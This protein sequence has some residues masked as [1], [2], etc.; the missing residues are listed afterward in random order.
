DRR[1]REALRL[2][3]EEGA[4]YDEAEARLLEL[5][6]DLA[7]RV[8]AR[9]QVE[10]ELPLR[11]AGHAS[12]ERRTVVRVVDRAKDRRRRDG[13]LRHERVEVADPD[14]RAVAE[15]PT[16]RIDHR[17]LGV[18]PR[19]R[20]AAREQVLPEA[21]VAAGEVEHFVSLPQ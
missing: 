13:R 18:D 2:R 11:E 1:P 3:D 21:A 17:R 12:E 14:R 19:V 8:L 20:E 10:D 4:Q 5:G 9:V 7:S 15:P 6:N 16:G